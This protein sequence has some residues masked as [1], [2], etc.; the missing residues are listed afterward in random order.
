MAIAS[1][2]H[3]IQKLLSFDLSIDW[4]ILNFTVHLKGEM[5]KIKQFLSEKILSIVEKA[6]SY[7]GGIISELQHIREYQRKCLAKDFTKRKSPENTNVKL[8]QMTLIVTFEYEDFKNIQKGLKRFFPKSDKIIKFVKEIK[9][10]EDNLGVLGRHELGL[11]TR[12][13][14]RYFTDFEV[15]D[16]LPVCVEYVYISYYR[17]LP[18]V[19]SIIFNFNLSDKVSST[20]NI[21]QNREYL[22]PV[23]FKRFWSINK[24]HYSY[25]MFYGKGGA[26]GAVY[27]EKNTLR[28][29]LKNW[30][31]KS[32]KWNNFL[33]DT[34]S[35]VDVYEI[36]GNPI[37]SGELKEWISNYSHWLEDFGISV[38]GL[39]TLI[40]DDI[41]YSMDKD[42]NACTSTDVITKFQ[43]ETKSKSEDSLRFKV[44]AVAIRSALFS[45]VDRYNIKVENL[46]AK[47][48]KS[49]NK[50]NRSVLKS[51]SSVK[52]LKKLVAL[53]SRLEHEVTKS[54]QWVVEIIS[55]IGDLKRPPKGEVMNLGK[56]LVQDIQY[57]I[58]QA[59]KTVEIIDAGLTSYL[60]VQNVYVMYKL[61]RWMFILSIVVTVATI[62]CVISGWTNLKPVL[63]DWFQL[64]MS[65]FNT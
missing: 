54:S 23:I 29:S 17:I 50:S 49:L 20:I 30:I 40:S 26:Y 7:R 13:S 36:K 46:N 60:S 44:R 18:S 3:I 21:L 42:D 57:Q 19:V 38:F 4:L 27:K 63:F 64:F 65:W 51:A 47:G 22:S 55:E 61:Q 41:I 39:D 43:S 5:I 32:F 37:N 24:I 35:F 28:T 14:G 11:I 10:N 12:E 53:I 48:F 16:D 15:V 2:S 25:S 58:K 56:E 45:L 9:K 31:K 8:S 62:V 6:P 34:V 52:E 59:K 33:M 1:S